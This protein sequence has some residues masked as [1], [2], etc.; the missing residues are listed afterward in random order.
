MPAII[1][2]VNLNSIAE[3]LEINPGDQI[4]SINDKKLQ[5]LIDYKYLVAAEDISLHI[6]RTNGEEEIFDGIGLR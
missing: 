2:T 3:D 1:S 6:K 5:D 4:V